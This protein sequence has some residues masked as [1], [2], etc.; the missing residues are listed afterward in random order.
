MKLN[1]GKVVWVEHQK[2]VES[3]GDENSV[4]QSTIGQLRKC[5]H[6]KFDVVRHANLP[7][8]YHVVHHF[9]QLLSI[10]N[11]NRADIEQSKFISTDICDG[12][13]H[14]RNSLTRNAKSAL[15]DFLVFDDAKA[16]ILHGHVEEEIVTDEDAFVKLW[17][18][19]VN[20]KQ[21]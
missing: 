10:H 13:R 14:I 7:Q 6:D 20:L 12:S 3:I 16:Q 2:F 8:F 19:E 1:D 11:I 15:P 17:P 5:R 4:G 18:V 9:D 21:Q